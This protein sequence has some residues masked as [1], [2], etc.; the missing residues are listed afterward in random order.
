M[1]VFGGKGGYSNDDR[2]K[3][4]ARALKATKKSAKQTYRASVIKEQEGYDL[5]LLIAMGTGALTDEELQLDR[6]DEYATKKLIPKR[7][8]I[9]VSQ[10]QLKNEITRRWEIACIMNDDPPKKKPALSGNIKALQS[11][12]ANASDD[13]TV[14]Y[15]LEYESE[16]RFIKKQ[17]NKILCV[18]QADHEAAEEAKM[19]NGEHLRP[20]TIMRMRVIHCKL[21]HFFCN[22]SE[23]IVT[24]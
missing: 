8:A 9:K 23:E 5:A 17:I 24:C 22:D 11:K 10:Q 3:D 19:E 7:K 14:T 20:E 1:S 2:L 15:P 16:K 12:L 21:C 13:G 18:I 4:E 6:M